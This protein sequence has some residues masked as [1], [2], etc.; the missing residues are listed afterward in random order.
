MKPEE[1]A[2]NSSR[3]AESPI[4]GPNVRQL[5]SQHDA[6]RLI[7]PIVSRGWQHDHGAVT[8]PSH[9]H[10]HFAAAKEPNGVP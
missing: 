5:V 4:R 7:R 10:A 2:R 6:T 3:D 1:R 9:R 8:T